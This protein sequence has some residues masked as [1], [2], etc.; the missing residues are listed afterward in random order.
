MTIRKSANGL[1]RF[2][3]AILL[4]GGRDSSQGPGRA[5]V[6][7][8]AGNPRCQAQGLVP[9]QVGLF[10][11]R[12]DRREQMAARGLFWPGVAL[13]VGGALGYGGAFLYGLRFAYREDQ[14][15]WLEPLFQICL[16]AGVLGL[17]LVLAGVVARRPRPPD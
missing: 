15:A 5:P 2:A 3:G 6:L 14:P 17:A 16:G 12:R 9:R 10:L 7:A 1:F 8:R 4:Y 13:L 11:V